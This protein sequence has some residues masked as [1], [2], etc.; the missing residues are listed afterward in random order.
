VKNRR[1]FLKLT[2]AA[3]AAT[4]VLDAA[5]AEARPASSAK[6]GMVKGLTLLTMRRKGEYCLGVKTGKG[7]L[8]VQQAAKMLK[9]EA[10]G[11]MDDLLQNERGIA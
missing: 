1:E 5:G 6:R 10:P 8:D 3:L 2:G 4:G 7:I 11:T 9:M